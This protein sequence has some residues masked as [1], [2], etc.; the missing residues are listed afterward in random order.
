ML[1]VSQIAKI[2]SKISARPMEDSRESQIPGI[3]R[4]RG[5]ASQNV[6]RPFP[7]PSR[8][9]NR[10]PTQEVPYASDAGIIG[11]GGSSSSRPSGHGVSGGQTDLSKLVSKVALDMHA[12]TSFSFL[13]GFEDKPRRSQLSPR[14]L[15]PRSVYAE[16]NNFDLG[17][18]DFPVEP[19]TAI[20]AFHDFSWLYPASSYERCA[21]RGT[22]NV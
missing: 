19:E 7:G 12:G 1:C 9:L 14:A 8:G 2:R 21:S 16:A 6:G 15:P 13:H 17:A 3:N 4:R 18:C 10:R 22:L 5:I 11:A 20:D